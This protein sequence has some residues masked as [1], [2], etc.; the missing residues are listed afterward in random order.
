MSWD[1][2][3]VEICPTCEHVKC[4][5][6]WNYT[7]NCNVMISVVVEAMGYSLASHWLI[8]HMGKSWF[9]VLDG[10]TGD[11]GSVFL[12]AIC[13][14]LIG[15]PEHFK[16]M[17]PAGGWGSYETLLPVLQEMRDAGLEY[18]CATWRVNG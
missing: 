1:A 8:G 18:P 14:G 3:L 16:T 7:H 17:N 2:S 6:S 5:R 12:S 10:L 11:G 4:Y 9:R 15:D 13:T